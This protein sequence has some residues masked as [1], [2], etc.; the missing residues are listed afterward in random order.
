[1]ADEIEI[2]AFRAGTP[3]SKGITAAQLQEAVSGYDPARNPAPVVMGHPKDD[4]SA[5]SFG[6]LADARVDGNK[7]FV[8]I[9]GLADEAKDGVRKHRI[10]NRSMAFWH[11][12]HPSNPTP[13]KLS[14]RHLGLLGGSLPAIPNMAPLRF[15][16]DDETGELIADGEPGEAI[17]FGAPVEAKA[18]EIDLDELAAKVADKLKPEAQPGKE[19][20]VPLTEAELEAREAELK[21][22]E[23]KLAEDETTFAAKA[24][25]AAKAEKA[26]REEANATFAAGL[27]EAGK[28]PAGHKDDLV[29]ILNALPCEVLKFSGDN[30]EAPA[31]ALKRIL[32]DTSA[33]IQFGAMTPGGTP[34]SGNDDDEESKA[35]AEANAKTTSAW[36]K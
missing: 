18:P 33:T 17:I 8:K 4:D 11:P 28:F 6:R 32:A 25:A 35:L 5:P 27:V 22:R 13:G 36:R 24:E 20:S 14:F 10:L 34:P 3:A 23:D 15:S 16:A 12:N 26:S 9:E 31:A 2:E 30:E 1:M 29:A 19:F 21:A 7:L